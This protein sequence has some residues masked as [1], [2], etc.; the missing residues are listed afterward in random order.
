MVVSEKGC[1]FAARNQLL[2]KPAAAGI[3]STKTMENKQIKVAVING[4]KNA[5]L[6]DVDGVQYLL[7]NVSELPRIDDWQYSL[8]GMQYCSNMASVEN[9][10]TVAVFGDWLPFNTSTHELREMFMNK[11][12]R[13]SDNENEPQPQ[14]KS[15]EQPKVEQPKQPQTTIPADMLTNFAQA[16]AATIAPM[17][18]PMV[19]QSVEENTTAIAAAVKDDILTEVNAQVAAAVEKLNIPQIVTLRVDNG[20]ETREIKGLQ[21]EKLQMIIKLAA[22]KKKIYMY[23]PA[24]TGKNVIAKQVADALGLQ[25]YSCSQIVMKHELIGY[26]DANGNY[27]AT[28]FYRAF[29][30]GGL[31]FFDELDS[32]CPDAVVAIN[33]AIENRY[34]EFPGQGLLQ[35]HEN[36]Q[37]LAAGNTCGVGATAQYTGRAAL[38][39]STLNRFIVVNVDYSPAIENAIAPA[40]VVK[41]CRDI[42]TYCANHNI[43]LVVSYRTITDLNDALNAELSVEDALNCAVYKYQLTA[44]QVEQINNAVNAVYSLTK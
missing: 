37:V 38:D 5:I 12:P 19:Q 28:D 1:S 42:R 39:A 17:V 20:R 6:V 7:H 23:G 13:K 26:C 3:C 2:I 32:S 15:D 29:T 18:Q 25:F 34:L 11:R 43:E 30:N 44:A 24:G 41:V 4:K 14:P 36:F 31:F 21:H 33:Q 40:N 22:M 10:A 35:A 27:I 16:I 8:K 9:I